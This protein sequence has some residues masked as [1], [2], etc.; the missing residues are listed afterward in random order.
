MKLVETRFYSVM[1]EITD[2]ILLGIVWIITSLPLITISS[3]C[4]AVYYVID[5]WNQGDKGRILKH[6]FVGF[7]NQIMVNL[8]SSLWFI[9]TLYLINDQITNLTRESNSI[10]ILFI[11]A[12]I[13]STSFY[14]RLVANF[15]KESY[16]DTILSK[17]KKSFLDVLTHFLSNLCIVMLAYLFYLLVVIFPPMIFIFSGGVWKLIYVLLNVNF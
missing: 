11:I 17:L 8:I 16:Q 9:T 2:Y 3:S 5:C 10:L 4:S 12:F 7:K 15:S 1:L 13:F 14:F 6:Y